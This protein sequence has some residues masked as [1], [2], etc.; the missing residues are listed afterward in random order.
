MNRAS[1]LLGFAG[2]REPS[3]VDESFLSARRAHKDMIRQEIDA[4][5][6]KGKS[7]AEIRLLLKNMGFGD[8]SVKKA[9]SA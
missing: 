3:G 7:D 9:L 6:A 4:L 2:V 1:R 5:R 8:A